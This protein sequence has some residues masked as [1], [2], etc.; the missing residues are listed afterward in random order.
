MYCVLGRGDIDD[1]RQ[2][3]HDDDDGEDER[4]GTTT[5]H[6]QTQSDLH[7]YTGRQRAGTQAVVRR[8][9]RTQHT[10]VLHYV[11]CIP[12]YYVIPARRGP[13]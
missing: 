1:V 8:A 9:D 13:F 3:G 10:S 12:T 6:V 5:E 4:R 2:M 7:R 11:S